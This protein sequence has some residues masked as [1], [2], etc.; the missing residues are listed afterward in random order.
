VGRRGEGLPEDVDVL[1]GTLVP[2]E[3]HVHA[4]HDHLSPSFLVVFE[5]V[6]GVVDSIL[7]VF[8]LGF[9]V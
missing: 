3:V 5:G 8:G 9:R 1:A 6:D 4:P 7:F 2:A